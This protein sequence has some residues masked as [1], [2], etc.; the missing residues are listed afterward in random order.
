M[1]RARAGG[2]S[3]LGGGPVGG[4]MGGLGRSG[5]GSGRQS[6]ASVPRRADASNELR[7]AVALPLGTGTEAE[8]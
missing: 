8:V 1:L 3:I 7:D 4:G 2:A 6:L 5:L